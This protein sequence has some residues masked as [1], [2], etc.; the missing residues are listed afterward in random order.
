M[1]K[2]G[3]QNKLKKLDSKYLSML[4]I[5]SSSK[6]TIWRTEYRDTFNLKSVKKKT[7]KQNNLEN[8]DLNLHENLENKRKHL[9][10]DPDMEQ[11]TEKDL[12]YKTKPKNTL[13]KK[14]QNGLIPKNGIQEEI[15]NKSRNLPI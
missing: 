8:L 2:T 15:F 1:E 5:S 10:D 13:I 6:K 4:K 9:E 11:N 14:P 12:I 3:K 7:E